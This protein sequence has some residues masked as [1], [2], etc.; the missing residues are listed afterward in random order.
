MQVQ[1]LGSRRVTGDSPSPEIELFCEQHPSESHANF[2]F[3]VCTPKQFPKLF[4]RRKDI[5][6]KKLLL[7]YQLQF[8][9]RQSSEISYPHCQ[10]KSKHL[11]KA[12]FDT[13]EDISS[14]TTKGRYS[15]LFPKLLKILGALVPN[16]CLTQE[17]EISSSGV[18]Q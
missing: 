14:G 11:T 13:S 12:C 7:L 1:L 16:I 2:S 10:E 3:I 17:R 15:S 5:W 6:N 18:A 9:A 4:W 8:R